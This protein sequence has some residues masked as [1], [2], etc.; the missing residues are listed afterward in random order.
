MPPAA[1]PGE[2][3]PA[4]AG[5]R[6][7]RP[8]AGAARRGVS[9]SRVSGTGSGASQATRVSSCKCGRSSVASRSNATAQ[10]AATVTRI[11]RPRCRGRAGRGFVRR[12]AVGRCPES[13][14]GGQQRRPPGRLP[15]AGPRAGRRAGRRRLRSGSGT[16]SGAGR[17]NRRRL[18][19]STSTVVARPSQPGLREVIRTWPGRWRAGTGAAPR[20]FGVVEHQQPP[21]PVRQRTQQPGH[22]HG[23]ADGRVGQVEGLGQSGQLIRDQGRV[24]GG[25]PPGHVVVVAVAVGVL[26]RGGGFADPA[27]AVHRLHRHPPAAGA[28]ARNWASSSVRPVNRAVRAGMLRTRRGRHLGRDGSGQVG[29]CVQQRRLQFGRRGHGRGDE[30]G[31]LQPLP[32]RQLPVAVSDVEE[33]VRRAGGAATPSRKTSR[34]MPSSVAVSNSSFGVGH[35]RPLPHRAARS[36]TRRSAHRRRPRRPSAGRT[37]PPALVPWPRSTPCR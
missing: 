26:D 29:Q 7:R 5:R 16:R 13:G 24:F 11:A 3:R 10:D 14:C 30:S 23:G 31:V 4:R 9:V 27:H 32:E 25:H 6:R 15:G 8:A 1:Q 33:H 22:G 17:W 35:L 21:L 37:L 36:G 12:A 20:V 19:S 18:N 2:A 28:A 34:A